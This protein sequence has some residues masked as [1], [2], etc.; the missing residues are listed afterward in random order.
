MTPKY[1]IS[2][3]AIDWNVRHVPILPIRNCCTESLALAKL[4]RRRQ[5]G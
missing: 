3:A 1:P 5:V 4:A 2:W